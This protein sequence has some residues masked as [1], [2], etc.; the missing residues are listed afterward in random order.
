MEVI[1]SGM[2]NEMLTVNTEPISCAE[3]TDC[4]A[5]HCALKAGRESLQGQR[6][7]GPDRG[8]ERESLYVN[9]DMT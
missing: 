7:Q 8:R 3:Q 1:L 6:G 9:T 4:W 2:S 5:L